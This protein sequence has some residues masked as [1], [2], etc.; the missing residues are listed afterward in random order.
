MANADV[1]NTNSALEEI[2]P[3]PTMHYN[4]GKRHADGDDDDRDNE[5]YGNGG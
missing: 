5:N 4:V 1:F 3:E 2:P